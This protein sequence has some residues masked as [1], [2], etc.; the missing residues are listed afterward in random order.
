MTTRIL[1][2]DDNSDLRAALRLLLEKRLDESTIIEAHDMEQLLA[3]A[4]DA[5]PHCVVLDWELPGRP[6]GDRVQVLHTLV[7]GIHIVVTS[8]RPEAREEAL[9]DGADRFVAKSD[10]PAAIL[11]AIRSCCAA[12]E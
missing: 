7:P 5:L 8:A 3:Q 12:K 10:S 2:A 11:D 9:A 1:L 4:E 6:R